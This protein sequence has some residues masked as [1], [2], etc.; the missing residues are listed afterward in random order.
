VFEA[1]RSARES[2]RYRRESLPLF[3]PGARPF[4]FLEELPPTEDLAFAAL[5]HG[6]EPL[7][8]DL[9]RLDTMDDADLGLME[10][11]SDAR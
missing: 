8:G 10:D 3:Y 2:A 5:V 1:R 9:L 6:W 4:V 7:Q 11:G